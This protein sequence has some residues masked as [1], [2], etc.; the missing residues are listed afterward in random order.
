MIHFNNQNIFKLAKINKAIIIKRF[1]FHF[2]VNDV[3]MYKHFR[4]NNIINTTIILEG[5]THF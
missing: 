4:K 3:E 2:N 5:I 1:F